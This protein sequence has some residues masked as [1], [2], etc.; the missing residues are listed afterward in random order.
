M[1][2]TTNSRVGYMLT[3]SVLVDLLVPSYA[4]AHNCLEE[5]ILDDVKRGLV[6]ARLSD[7]LRS[8][9][10]AALKKGRANV[11]D[12]DLAEQLSKAMAKLGRRVTPTPDRTLDKMAALL[13]SID[14]NVGRASDATRSMLES[15][16]GRAALEKSIEATGQFLAERL[17]PVRAP[18]G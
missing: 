1:S 18:K 13:A 10:W 12:A 8:A 11:E 15:P 14:I 9:I 16:Q 4:Q 5:E 17:Y 7:A 6:D 3:T 2:S